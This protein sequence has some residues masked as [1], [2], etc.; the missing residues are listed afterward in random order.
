MKRGMDAFSSDEVA[1][2]RISIAF[3]VLLPLLLKRLKID[4]RKYFFGLLLTGVFGNLIPAFL[5]TL[6]ETKISSSLAGMLNALTPM[7]TIIL[8]LIWLKTST[9][10]NQIIGIVA[11]LMAAVTLMY[12][13]EGEDKFK[14]LSFGLLVILATVFYAISINVIKKYLN[15]LGSITTTVWAFS[16]TG[17]IAL[18]YLFGFTDFTTHVMEHPQAL[19]SLG[20][21]AILAIM[22]SALSVIAYNYLIKNAGTV[23][24]S[25]CTYL[26][27]IVAIFWGVLD[28]ETVNLS[29]ILSILVII[30]SVYLINND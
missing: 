14:N 20:Y 8:S 6:A 27:P 12:F 24:A 26:I 16:I 9:S 3:L 29:Q 18:V 22:G 28:G 5:F 17:P 4:F 13:E 19:S 30:F 2:L 23:F 11:G 10:R 15:D 1:A 21:T 25:S 7:F